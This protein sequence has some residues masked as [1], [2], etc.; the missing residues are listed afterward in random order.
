MLMATEKPIKVTRT[1]AL[2]SVVRVLRHNLTKAG[3]DPVR[4]S[5][6]DI[7][8]AW[9][10][11]QHDAE[12]GTYGAAWVETVNA[13]CGETRTS[14]RPVH[15]LVLSMVRGAQPKRRTKYQATHHP[16]KVAEVECPEVDAFES[17]GRRFRCT[18]CGRVLQRR[19]RHQP[20]EDGKF[21]YIEHYRDGSTYFVEPA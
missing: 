4:A 1:E 10:Q 14:A 8:G 12:P 16:I 7:E 9:N 18:V 2:E 21:G 5:D 19:V 13:W 20:G 6:E 17:Q 15:R 3:I 11:M